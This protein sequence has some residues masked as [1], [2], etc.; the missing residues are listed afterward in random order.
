MLRPILIALAAA[1]ATLPPMLDAQSTAAPDLIP[2]KSIFGNP[3]RASATI[4][5]DGRQLAFL[6]PRDGVLNVWVA[7]LGALDQAKP[8]THDKVRPVFR[9][10]WT[11]DSTR[12]LYLQDK[13]GNENW[14]LVGVELASGKETA[15]TNFDKA[16][17]RVLS[18]TPKVPGE[19]LIGINNRNPQL[20]DVYRLDLGSGKMTL[21]RQ[22][23][24][25]YSGFAPDWNLNV[26]FGIRQTPGGGVAIDRFDTAGK[27]KQFAT[28]PLDDNFT[29]GIA[30]MTADGSTLYMEDSRERDTAAL[31]AIDL[32]TEKATVIGQHPK[33]DVGGVLRDPLTG[34]VEAYSANYLR[35]EWT[36]VGDTLKDDIAFL[37][38]EA[39][40][41][42]NVVSSSNDKRLWTLSIDRVNEPI[43]FWLYDRPAK[44]LT[45]LF[46][47]RPDLEGKPLASMH[48]V[49]IRTRDGLTL[50]AYLSLPPGSDRDNDGRP[51][52]PL[53]LVLNVHG[54][55]WARD[56]FGYHPESQW[57]A[58]RG[59]A[60]L[61]VNYRGSTGFG[62]KFTNAGNR[63]FA[64]RM[65]D[66]LIDAVN[67]A[68]DGRITTKD[69]VAI[70]GGSYGG[71]ATLTGLTFTPEVFACGV[72]IVGPSN[73]VT[74]IESFPAY[75][76][77]F[78]E[79]SWYKRVGDPR[80]D[81][82]RKFLLSRSPITRVDQIRRPLLIAQGA[83]DP[84][85]VQ[86][87]SDQLV[88]EMK[89]RKIPVTYVLYADEGHGFAR[90]ENR[91]SFYAVTEG[92]L[93]KCLGGRFEPIGSDFKG[94]SA[95]VLEGVQ[96]VPGLADVTRS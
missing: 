27:P 78:L 8:V 39:R 86:K 53:P 71:Y 76:Q 6:A 40:G 4:S 69:K 51:D 3:T 50:V 79:G 14:A 75:W 82:G 45:K 56:S 43:A 70:Y 20:H 1:G 19:I 74:L 29:T 83:N 30:G 96:N 5:P 77:P 84:R 13:G 81:E 23:D 68:I 44:K 67:W 36:P 2:R 73:L 93:A 65:H 55:P 11:A 33:A 52:G 9:F 90:P 34:V 21:V 17:V 89:A 54:G 41:E 95:K 16:Q 42:W 58:N 92:F 94:S 72:D 35:N 61:Q 87:E 31:V 62:K 12:I 47:A 63:E 88:A 80:N 64:G 49:E 24:E 7:P 59:Y 26:A 85:V 66:D 46:T 22:N 37:N 38:R 91:T 15:Y 10:F 25:G 48:P 18:V 60:T 32:A 28:I 57:L